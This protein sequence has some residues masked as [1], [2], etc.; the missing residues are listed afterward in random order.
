MRYTMNKK[1]RDLKIKEARANIG[2]ELKLNL[3]KN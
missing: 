3:I 2:K 1:E